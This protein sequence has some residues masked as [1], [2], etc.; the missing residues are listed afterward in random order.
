MIV[1]GDFGPQTVAKMNKAPA[2][3]FVIIKIFRVGDSGEIVKRIQQALTNVGFVT[4][5]TGSFDKATEQSV[6]N[7]QKEKGLQPDGVVGP[8]TLTDLGISI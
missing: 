4:S 3:G 8:K 1:D 5:V 6:I 7:F 2:D